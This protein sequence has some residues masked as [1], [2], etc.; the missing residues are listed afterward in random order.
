MSRESE[1][2]QRGLALYNERGQEIEALGKG[3]Y[4]VPGTD[5]PYE[6]DLDVFAEDPAESC[7][8]KDFRHRLSTLP[9]PMCCKHI[10]AA[11]ICR[12]K[13]IA[14]LKR[15]HLARKK[16]IPAALAKELAA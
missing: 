8:C 15:E 12:A 6:V 9:A 14:E 3:R 13:R 4:L 7:E 2:A 5:G 11:A 10:H 1:R 16:P